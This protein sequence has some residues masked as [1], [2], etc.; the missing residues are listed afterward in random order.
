VS[1]QTLQLHR[2]AHEEGG[3]KGELDA[4]QSIAGGYEWSSCTRD[5]PLTGVDAKLAPLDITDMEHPMLKSPV[6]RSIRT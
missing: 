1:K 2:L 3:E 5:V 6:M 4:E